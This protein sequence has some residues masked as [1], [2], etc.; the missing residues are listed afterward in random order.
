MAVSKGQL[1]NL[2]NVWEGGRV[3]G[4][5]SVMS[6]WL[7]LFI[8]FSSIYFRTPETHW[9][10]EYVMFF[11]LTWPLITNV[12]Q[13]YYFCIINDL[14]IKMCVE[15]YTINVIWYS[16]SF[17]Q[18]QRLVRTKFGLLHYNRIDLNDITATFSRPT[19]Q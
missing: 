14:I 10:V 17:G 13:Y 6:P 15:L 4:L 2:K 5:T 8:T 7:N 3:G 19:Y 11:Y 12:F 18:F 16:A 1:L 9:I